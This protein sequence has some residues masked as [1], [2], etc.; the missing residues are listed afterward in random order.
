MGYLVLGYAYMPVV[1]VEYGFY[2][3]HLFWEVGDM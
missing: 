1:V 2:A 3:M